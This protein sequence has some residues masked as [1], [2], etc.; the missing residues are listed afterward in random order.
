MRQ[1]GSQQH[2][3][4]AEEQHN[5]QHYPFISEESLN[6]SDETADALSARN[7]VSTV[8]S[9][10]YFDGV[11]SGLHRI[12]S[13]RQSQRRKKSKR[14]ETYKST[15]PEER[16]KG[17]IA[18]HYYH[19]FGLNRITPILI[20][21]CFSLV[22]AGVFYAIEHDN[23][24]QVEASK[25]ERM[26]QLRSKAIDRMVYLV[27]RPPPTYN[28]VRN[29]TYNFLIWYEAGIPELN[30]VMSTGLRWDFWGALFYVCTIYTTIGGLL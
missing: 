15:P 24:L 18:Q 16:T 19:K 29:A 28:T 25:K 1:S 5:R 21:I 12:A 4:P 17:Q 13:V 14:S 7:T 20:L 10:V 23:Q 22:G 9:Y 30:D 27:N 2:L 8:D 26:E 3:K 6:Y 11:S